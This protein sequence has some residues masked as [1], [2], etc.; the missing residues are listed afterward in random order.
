M[1][2][3]FLFVIMIIS[4]S[5]TGCLQAGDESDFTEQI[6]NLED[7]IEALEKEIENLESEKSNETIEDLELEIENLESEKSNETQLLGD[8][9]TPGVSACIQGLVIAH[10][11]GFD[12]GNSVDVALGS[13]SSMNKTVEFG[14][15]SGD[16][17]ATICAKVAQSKYGM[18]FSG[19]NSM[20]GVESGISFMEEGNYASTSIDFDERALLGSWISPMKHTNN[21]IQNLGNCVQNGAWLRTDANLMMEMMENTGQN[22]YITHISGNVGGCEWLSLKDLLSS[23]GESEPKNIWM[24]L[25]DNLNLTQYSEIMREYALL[26]TEPHVG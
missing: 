8:S 11:D 14:L 26:D 17:A 9:G 7:K 4:T 13:V 12:I 20:A 25:K 10:I 3:S 2:K 21:S 5:F 16:D 6:K 24:G 1:K 22:T 19:W 15:E 23:A 18:I